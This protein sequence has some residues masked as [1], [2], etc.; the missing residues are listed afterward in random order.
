MNKRK[1]TE[2]FEI[3]PQ[4]T[5]YEMNSV[6]VVRNRQTGYILKW[7]KG[8]HGTAQ[9]NLW[10]DAGKKICVSKPTLLWLL[11][12]RITSQK[13]P[14]MTVISKGNRVLRFDSRRQCAFY[15][16]QTLNKN[17]NT[18]WWHFKHRKATIGGWTIHYDLV[19]E[20]INLVK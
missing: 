10:N 11:H 16:A 20:T 17:Q 8:T 7:L 6:G 19:K 1:P 12:G 18:I 9:I 14:I 13:A 3:I 5:R 2:D 15:L 4:A